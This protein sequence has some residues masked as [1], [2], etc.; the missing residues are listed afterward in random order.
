MLAFLKNINVLRV[1][2]KIAYAL[3]QI[4]P[5]TLKKSWRK[6]IPLGESSVEENA[7]S[8]ESVLNDVF[9]EQLAALN[10]E[11]MTSD[12]DGWFHTGGPGYEDFDEQG[13][14]DL[15]SA[16][17]G[18]ECEEEKNAD[19]NTEHS[20]QKAPCPFSHAE[21]MQMCNHCLTWLRVQPEETVSNTSTLVRLRGFAAE[22]RESSRK[23]SKINSFFSKS[24]VASD[25]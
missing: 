25:S 15:V 4:S 12:I 21:A 22:K 16:A 7:T 14:V 17:E 13:L 1:V 20:T 9:L 3:E 11:L 10:I 24:N 8:L 18:N 5:K 19:K 23:L 6:L 2:E